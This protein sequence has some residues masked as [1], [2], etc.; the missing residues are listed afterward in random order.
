[1][2]KNDQIDLLLHWTRNVKRAQF[3]HY[4]M[5]HR[6]RRRYTLIGITITIIAG[7]GG[8]AFMT[9]V[10]NYF[11]QIA[12]KLNVGIGFLLFVS[13]V[14]SAIQTLLRLDERAQKY[15]STATKYSAVKRNLLQLHAMAQT[16]AVSEKR[17]DE[18]R[19]TI[20]S[21][22]IEAPQI[23]DKVLKRIEKGMPPTPFKNYY[24]SKEEEE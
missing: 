12:S 21:I 20:D 23:P 4:R 17:I 13:A 3:G 24:Q 11:P 7:A 14:L 22:A 19:K 6:Y 10:P 1:M 16:K 5:S 9:N 15:L 2:D 8:S 18:I